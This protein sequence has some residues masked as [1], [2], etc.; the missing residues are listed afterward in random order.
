MAM[1]AM[2]ISTVVGLVGSM[3]QASA[4]NA[5]AKAQE[6]IAEFNAKQKEIEASR[7][8]AEG[9]LRGELEK[10]DAQNLAGRARASFAQMGVDTSTGSP[11]LLEQDLI[12]EGSFRQNLEIASAQNEQR[13][14]Q[15]N[16]KADRFQG[17]IAAMS[18]RAQARASLLGGIGSAFGGLAKMSFG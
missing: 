17:Q 8:Q 1:A 16:A 12:S 6:Q 5:Q 14:L 11:L 7:R 18:S 3:A 10:K 13:S 9:V 2:L 4:L 15:E